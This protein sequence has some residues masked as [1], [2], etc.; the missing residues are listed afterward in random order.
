M[1]VEEMGVMVN[2]MKLIRTEPLEQQ[3]LVVVQEVNIMIPQPMGRVSLAV[4]V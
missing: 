4:Q 3:I 1:V 2:I